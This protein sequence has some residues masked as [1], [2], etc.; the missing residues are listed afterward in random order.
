MLE[1]PIEL[2]DLIM[3][4]NAVREWGRKSINV[5][6]CHSLALGNV[7]SPRTGTSLLSH[8]RMS[9]LLWV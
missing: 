7:T 1:C 3:I 8:P 4:T 2:K 9:A 5:T 6:T